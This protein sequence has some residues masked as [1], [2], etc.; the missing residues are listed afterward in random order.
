MLGC[1]PARSWRLP[2]P[3]RFSSPQRDSASLVGTS[4]R[5]V[6]PDLSV[7][8]RSA[9]LRGA[10]LLLVACALVD[11]DDSVGAGRL[12]QEREGV[13]EC[14]IE[15]VAGDDGVEA[16]TP[17]RG[18]QWPGDEAEKVQFGAGERLD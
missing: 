15:R 5:Y 4:R 14:R 3:E 2:V 17:G 6:R 11:A 18:R 12:A 7:R 13:L 9:P 1:R 10:P 16:V 8:Q